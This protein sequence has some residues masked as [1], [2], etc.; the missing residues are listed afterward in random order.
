MVPIFA[1]YL[2]PASYGKVAMA[3]VLIALLQ[4][5]ASF[6]LENAIAQ[7]GTLFTTD[8]RRGAIRAIMLV[9]S[10]SSA[11]LFSFAIAM[12]FFGSGSLGGFTLTSEW[13]LIIVATCTAIWNSGGQ[14]LLVSTGLSKRHTVYSL[15]YSG[16]FV[17]GVLCFVVD[18]KLDFTGW[19]LA[20]I[21][22]SGLC[23]LMQLW[24]MMR[25]SARPIDW[26]AIPK[27]LYFGLPLIPH[28]YALWALNSADRWVIAS[29]GSQEALGIYFI[30]LQIAMIVGVITNALNLAFYPLANRILTSQDVIHDQTLIGPL[31][32]GVVCA[33][34]YAALVVACSAPL[35]IRLGL[36]IN[37]YESAN[38]LPWLAL[39]FA[40]QGVYFVASRGIWVSG[41]SY[42]VTVGTV[43]SGAL[44]A[45]V[46]FWTLPGLGI[47]GAGLG[48]VIAN[49]SLAT[50]SG[51][52]AH[53]LFPIPWP[54]K[55]WVKAG[56]LAVICYLVVS[57]LVRNESLWIATTGLLTAA[58][59]FPLLLQLTGVL[60][61]KEVYSVLSLS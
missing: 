48:S 27:A 14:V 31:G 22:S 9:W 5:L 10:L 39:A 20:I 3:Q 6:G 2:P 42:W 4:P 53:S 59:L 28:S 43:A 41:K 56:L 7:S 8:A 24:D 57:G 16:L 45:I 37:Y 18:L 15:I 19:L 23:S 36:P 34:F 17:F 32:T 55:K 26:R 51:L 11:T 1:R 50:L 58:V 13:A 49:A 38:V 29:R 52:I 60:R 12:F 25:A 30:G 33:S 35:V 46:T 47:V 40:F 44:G 54:Y 61:L 21:F